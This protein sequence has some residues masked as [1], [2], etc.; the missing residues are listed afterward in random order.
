MKCWTDLVL[1]LVFPSAPLAGVLAGVLAEVLAG[2][3]AEAVHGFHIVLHIRP[4]L[5]SD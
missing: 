4:G 2:V 3:L 1:V 5:G